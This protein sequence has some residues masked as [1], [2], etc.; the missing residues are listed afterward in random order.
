MLAERLCM[1]T[2]EEDFLRQARGDKFIHLMCLFGQFA[3]PT[4]HHRCLGKLECGDSLF[5]SPLR[6]VIK[7][8]AFFTIFNIISPDV[9]CLDENEKNFPFFS[10]LRQPMFS[11]WLHSCASS[12]PSYEE[13]FIH[14]KYLC[15]SNKRAA[16]KTKRDGKT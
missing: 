2:P 6:S 16:K 7:R 4:H 5:V 1:A 13:M 10:S 15:L 12:A 9:I 3:I 14:I 11:S 8:L